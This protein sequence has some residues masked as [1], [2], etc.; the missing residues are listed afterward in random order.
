MRPASGSRSR[1]PD[2]PCLCASSDAG[3]VG[4]GRGGLPAAPLG[5]PFVLR[6]SRGDPAK[7][8]LVP[9]ET[10][11][12]ERPCRCLKAAAGEGRREQNGLLETWVG[13]ERPLKAPKQGVHFCRGREA[14][15][16]EE[17]SSAQPQTGRTSL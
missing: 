2:F 1:C 3:A 9:R 16:Y 5:L 15:A 7:T 8:L 4:C 6:V 13:E 10:A 11:E 12:G 14:V 17:V